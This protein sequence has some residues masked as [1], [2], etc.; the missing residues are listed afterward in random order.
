MCKTHRPKLKGLKASVSSSS[1]ASRHQ[2]LCWLA[3]TEERK[4]INKI[5]K[6]GVTINNTICSL[7]ALSNAIS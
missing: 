1:R 6:K 2:S 3:S 4:N 5:L 7:A